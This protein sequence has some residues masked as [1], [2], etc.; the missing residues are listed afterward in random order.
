VLV[1]RDFDLDGIAYVESYLAA[2]E[3]FGKQ[4]GSLL[5]ASHD[6]QAGNVLG[7]LAN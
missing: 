7:V 6:V 3:E 2:N 1:R 4:L 5:L